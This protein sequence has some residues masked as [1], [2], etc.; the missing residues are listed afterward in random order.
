[1]SEHSTPEERTEMPTDRRLGQLRREGALHHSIELEQTISLM[2]GFL[3]VSMMAPTLISHIKYVFRKAFEMIGSGEPLS[4]QDLREGFLGLVGLLGPDLMVIVG[5]IAVVSG[6]AVMLQTQWNIKEKKL[7]ID[8]SLLN[9]VN[10]VK[11]VFSISGFLNVGKALVKLAIILP[12]GYFSLKKFAPFM[13]QLIHMELDE[14]FVFTSTAMRSVF[15]KI[16]YV[17]I[18]LSL[19]DFFYGKFRWLKQNKMTK[20]EVKDERKSIEGDEE[21]KRSIMRKGWARIQQRLRETV[22][23]ADV[24]VTNPTHYSVA[25]K[26]DRTTMAAPIVVAKG[27]NFIALKIREIARENGIPVLER[28]PLARALYSSVEIGAVIPRE[29]FKAVAEVL[30]YVYRLKN[31]YR[32]AQNAKR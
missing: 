3:I 19:F 14:I 7:K 13:I 18:G 6:L 11:R 26:Y 12:I 29:L 8:L 15:W 21:T 32:Q 5:T 28:K 2:T 4:M 1:M 16:L 24:I 25:L 20:E 17:L 22:P 30:A 27:K 10:G 9:P 23:T 31:P